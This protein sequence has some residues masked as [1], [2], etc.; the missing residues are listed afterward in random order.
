MVDAGR[1][2]VRVAGHFSFAVTPIVDGE[3]QQVQR[4][5]LLV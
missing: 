5:P 4:R 3:A 2:S 1:I